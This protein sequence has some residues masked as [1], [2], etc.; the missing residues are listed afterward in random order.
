MRE[1]A[2]LKWLVQHFASQAEQC[3]HRIA[4]LDAQREV[5]DTAAAT[6]RCRLEVL[7]AEMLKEGK[8]E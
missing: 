4:E 2:H 3:V 7:E 5:Y 6:V 1:G 8:H